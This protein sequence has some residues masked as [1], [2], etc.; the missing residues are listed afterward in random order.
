MKTQHGFARNL[1]FVCL[2][3]SAD[4][5]TQELCATEETLGPVAQNFSFAMLMVCA[6]ILL[7]LGLL[8]AML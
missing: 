2:T 7:I 8:L 3:E 5:I 1:D 4:S 6:G